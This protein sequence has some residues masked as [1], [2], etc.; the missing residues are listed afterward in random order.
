MMA[1]T[2]VAAAGPP[3]PLELRLRLSRFHVRF[4][5]RGGDEIVSIGADSVYHREVSEMPVI[6]ISK[7]ELTRAGTDHLRG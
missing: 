7:V 4:K 5:I 1:A 3:I 6:Q 2:A